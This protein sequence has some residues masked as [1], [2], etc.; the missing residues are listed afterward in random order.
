MNANDKGR[1]SRRI[2]CTNM[3]RLRGGQLG[4]NKRFPGVIMNICSKKE[5]YGRLIFKLLRRKMGNK[6][7]KSQHDIDKDYGQL[8]FFPFFNEIE[9]RKPPIRFNAPKYLDY[10]ETK[11]PI[12]NVLYFKTIIALV[13]LTQN[14]RDAM[15]CKFF[16]A[17][18]CYRA[19][20]WF[21][22]LV[23]STI[24]SFRTIFKNN[25]H[26]LYKQ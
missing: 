23:P 6:M 18:L 1:T 24:T 2:G 17:T 5:S 14:K 21:N 26:K 12:T 15:M 22:N 20:K 13:S 16:A 4:Q 25:H 7:G 11:D 9:Q 3:S 19:H 8:C 10:Q